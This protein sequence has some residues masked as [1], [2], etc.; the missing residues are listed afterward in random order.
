M[1]LDKESA[2]NSKDSVPPAVDTGDGSTNEVSSLPLT[3][4]PGVTRLEQKED[5]SARRKYHISVRGVIPPNLV[6]R[7]SILHATATV[8]NRQ[9]DLAAPTTLQRR[10]SKVA[11]KSERN[12]HAQPTNDCNL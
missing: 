7:I 1:N 10:V 6:E 9:L 5:T 3:V 4:L 11:S 2:N 8:Q 12:G